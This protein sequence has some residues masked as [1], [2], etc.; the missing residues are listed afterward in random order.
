MP[1]LQAHMQGSNSWG[2]RASP[3]QLALA[4]A[5]LDCLSAWTQ[6]EFWSELQQRLH[7]LPTQ[8]SSLAKGNPLCITVQVVACDFVVKRLKV[9]ARTDHHCS[10]WVT[11]V[12]RCCLH[13]SFCGASPCVKLLLVLSCRAGSLTH[14][15]RLL[16][17]NQPVNRC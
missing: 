9:L 7:F 10:P 3:E 8:V 6:D 12:M 13:H 4:R 16:G 5:D 2:S 1:P 15:G 14:P 11:M 17:S